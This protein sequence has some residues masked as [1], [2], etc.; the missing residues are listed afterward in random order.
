MAGAHL[1]AVPP[2]KEDAADPPLQLWD[3]LLACIQRGSSSKLSIC[4]KCVSLQQRHRTFC[5]GVYRRH[6]SGVW[7]PDVFS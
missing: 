7:A 1:A 4:V 3:V 2:D 5:E 6:H